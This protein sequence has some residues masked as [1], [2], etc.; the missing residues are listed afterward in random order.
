[1][2]VTATAVRLDFGA[3]FEQMR[4]FFPG[5]PGQHAIL[6]AI[7]ALRRERGGII[8]GLS[9]GVLIPIDG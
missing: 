6:M 4:Q 9:Y 7:R 1:V 8:Q 3:G 2:L 5:V